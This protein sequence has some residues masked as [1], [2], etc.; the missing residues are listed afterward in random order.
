MLKE[1]ELNNIKLSLIIVSAVILLSRCGSDIPSPN[2]SPNIA[3]QIEGTETYEL[4][5][6][7]ISQ[8]NCGGNAEVENA[9][10]RSREIEHV[11]EVQSGVSINANG[12]VGFA[13]TDVEL[14]ATIASQLSYSYGDVESM[15]RSITVKASPGTNMQHTIR[16]LEVWKT[17]TAKVS[18]GDQEVVIPFRFRSDFKLELVESKDIGDCEALVDN[19]VVAE[20]GDNNLPTEQLSDSCFPQTGW[21]PPKLMQNGEWIY[22]CLSSGDENW[23]GQTEAWKATNWK[24]GSSQSEIVNIVIPDGATTMGLGCAPCTVQKPD[25]TTISSPNGSTFGP[26]QPNISFDVRQG[27]IYKVKIFGSDSCPSR[28]EVISPCS[29]EIYIW[30]NL[31]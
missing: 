5:I 17:G 4:D 21:T 28:P 9:I 23:V 26:F 18:V 15:A 31:Q 13:G 19:P 14:G 25:G 10:Q 8:P 11:M 3:V 16:L 2:P 12:Q 6:E 7:T 20:L 1:I 22:D 29:P 27:E 24:K 30:F